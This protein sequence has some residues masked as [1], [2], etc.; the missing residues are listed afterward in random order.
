MSMQNAGQQNNRYL[1][2]LSD[3][4]DTVSSAL[5]EKDILEGVL[6]EL[7]NSIPLDACWVH[8]YDISTK[9]LILIVQNGMPQPLLNELGSLQLGIGAVGKVGLERQAVSCND[10]GADA[11]YGWATA[12]GSGFHS[13]LAAPVIY[14]GQLVGLIGGL[15]TK[16]GLFTPNEVKLF[17]VVSSCVSDICRRVSLDHGGVQSKQRSEEITHTHLFLSASRRR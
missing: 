16:A 10:V 13:L 12:S 14:N 17:S 4:S 7:A 11:V 8:R 5:A 6:W 15:S 1:Y 3:I 9:T 2:L